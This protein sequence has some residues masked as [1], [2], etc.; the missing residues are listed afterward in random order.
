MAYCFA[1]EGDIVHCWGVAAMTEPR[2]GDIEHASSA[3]FTPGNDQGVDWS[4]A[5]EEVAV[6]P[7]TSNGRDARTTESGR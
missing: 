2:D 7:P 5:P 4:S 1:L 3:P 6:P